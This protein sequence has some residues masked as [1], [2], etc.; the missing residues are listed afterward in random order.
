MQATGFVKFGKCPTDR[1]K[2]FVAIFHPLCMTTKLEPSWWRRAASSEDS[3]GSQSG[4]FREVYRNCAVLFVRQ[5]LADDA[6]RP[7]ALASGPLVLVL[8]C[9]RCWGNMMQASTPFK[10]AALVL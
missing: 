4:C 9:N 2:P 3:N 10:T 6:E 7:H 5:Q 8:W 1:R